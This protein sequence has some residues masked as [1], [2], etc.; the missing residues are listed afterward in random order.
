M[1]NNQR[2]FGAL[3]AII[4]VVVIALVGGIGWR[5]YN[6]NKAVKPVA[7]TVAKKTKT[8]TPTKKTATNPTTNWTAFSSTTGGFSFKYPV[9]W[10]I[11]DCGE[12][13]VLLGTSS[14]NAGHCQSDATPLISLSSSSGDNRANYQ[15]DPTSF[16]DITTTAA[17]VNGVSGTKQ[18]GT[19]QA[20][21]D[22]SLGPVDGSK[23]ITYTFYNKG[24]TY[25]M[26]YTQAPDATDVS[27]NFE[28]MIAYTFEFN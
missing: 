8:T 13:T 27:A 19:Y 28:S 23:S 17:T 22:A 26:S 2:G 1:N 4:I 20:S 5:V 6:H 9:G 16:T 18:T 7:V 25:V 14:A 10:V 24:K 11:N 3:G 12:G 21:V 15:L